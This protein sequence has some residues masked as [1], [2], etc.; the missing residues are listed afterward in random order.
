MI[1]VYEVVKIC[2][3]EFFF[4]FL[5]LVLVVLFFWGSS[6][7]LLVVIVINIFVLVGILS[8]VFSVVCYVDVFV[9]CLGEFY[10]FLILSL[11]VVIFEVSLIFVLMVIGDVVLIL[12]WDIFYFI[13][14]IVIGGLVGFFL[15]LGGCKFVI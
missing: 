7:L 5:V 3:K 4:V 8:S 14:M 11:L 6:Q 1:Y 10:G 9:Y 12:M 13:I 15:L 2:Y